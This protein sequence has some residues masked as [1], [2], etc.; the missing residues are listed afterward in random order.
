MTTKYKYY[1]PLYQ[2]KLYNIITCNKIIGNIT[3]VNSSTH[4]TTDTQ[5]LND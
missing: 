4:T 3:N 5:N 1:T 2:M